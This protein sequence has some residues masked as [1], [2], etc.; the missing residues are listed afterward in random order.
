MKKSLFTL[1]PLVL[2][3]ACAPKKP[4]PAPAL[5]PSLLDQI[6]AL[7][8]ERHGQ[9]DYG[10]DHTHFDNAFMDRY[11]AQPG[12]AEELMAYFTQRGD[13]CRGA[14]LQLLCDTH[15]DYVQEHGLALDRQLNDEERIFFLRI[16]G[17]LNHPTLETLLLSHLEDANEAVRAGAVSTLAK[18]DQTKILPQLEQLA[19][20]E[21]STRV[22]EELVLNLSVSKHPGLAPLLETLAQRGPSTVTRAVLTT[23]STSDL[24]HKRAL[25]GS[26]ANSADAEVAAHA[27]FLGEALADKDKLSLK[28]TV[29]QRQDQVLEVDKNLQK[30]LSAAVWHNDIAEIDRLL[31]LGASLEAHGRR[32]VPVL[33]EAFYRD[34]ATL[35][36]CLKNAK[37]STADDRT[38]FMYLAQD[39]MPAPVENLELILAQGVPLDA[40]TDGGETA[41]YL[42]AM[43]GR[44]AIVQFLLAHGANPNLRNEIG[45][46]ALDIARIVGHDEIAALLEPVTQP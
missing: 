4:A 29:S 3:I 20:R 22:L 1:L 16:L 39:G 46:R 19:G 14:L 10:T 36:H 32:E 34:H 43:G 12:T 25:I 24:E 7:E 44:K 9:K 45:N 42:A 41:L 31:A 2:L 33:Y 18:I 28:P 26:Y 8:T 15:P 30:E 37:L 35:V 38:A 21:S 23:W 27:K 17:R 5:E 11:R 13:L 6:C 40:V